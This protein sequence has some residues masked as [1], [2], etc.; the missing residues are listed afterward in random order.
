MTE[1]ERFS[2]RHGFEPKETEIR[3]RHEASRK[4]REAVIAMAY[5]SGARPSR[6][7]SVMCRVLRTSPDPDN[8]SDANVAREV[9]GLLSSCDWYEVYDIIEAIWLVLLDVDTELPAEANREPAR[10]YFT[11]ELNLYFRKEGIGWQLVDGKVQLRG[12]EVFERSVGA[13]HAALTDS[14]RPTAAQELHQAL[15]DISRRPSPDVTGAIQHS[16]AALECV[17]RDVTGEQKPTL[18]ELLKRNP[19]LLPPPLG[20]CV[21]KAWGYASERGRHVR[22]GREPEIEDA[23]LV[24]GIAASVTHYLTRRSQRAGQ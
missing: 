3:V 17:V 5:E 19:D 20:Q 10:E 6:L 15:L 12:P 2:R 16:V 9:D 23:E 22:E 8:W 7:R 4:F 18:G 14:G 21:E 24:V 1:H 13:A 11:R